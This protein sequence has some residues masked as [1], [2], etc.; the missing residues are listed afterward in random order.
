MAFFSILFDDAP[1]KMARET[2]VMPDFFVDLNLDQ[3]IDAIT[4]GR[5][6]Y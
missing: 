1:A 2:Q 5:K 6:E 3:V 4:A